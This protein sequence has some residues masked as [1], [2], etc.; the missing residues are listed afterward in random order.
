MDCS[1]RPGSRSNNPI[2]LAPLLLLRP[3][4][5]AHILFAVMLFLRPLVVLLVAGW[6]WRGVAGLVVLAGAAV[7]HDFGCV[8]CVVLG[9]LWEWSVDDGLLG[10]M[11]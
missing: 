3:L 11:M 7:A 9:G 10:L 8:V 2:H 5:V 4:L 6:W 1:S